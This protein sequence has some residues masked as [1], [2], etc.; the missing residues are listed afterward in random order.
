M[1]AEHQIVFEGERGYVLSLAVFGYEYPEDSSGTNADWLEFELAVQDDG[2]IQAAGYLDDG[3]QLKVEF[4]QVVISRD[5]LVKA[6]QQ[7]A[8][9][10]ANYPNRP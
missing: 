6:R 3:I 9:V 7:L 2:S 4:R 10:V 1:R 5:A 8:A